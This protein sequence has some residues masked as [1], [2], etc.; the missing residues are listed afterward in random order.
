[1]KC[2]NKNENIFL[3]QNFGQVKSLSIMWYYNLR[4]FFSNFDY[5][6]QIYT[7]RLKGKRLWGRKVDLSLN[8]SCVIKKDFAE[9]LSTWDWE[10]N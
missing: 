9:A 7:L 8:F 5:W 1:M 3:V 10:K 6:K 2:Y 4:K